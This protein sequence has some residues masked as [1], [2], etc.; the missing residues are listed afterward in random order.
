MEMN[1]TDIFMNSFG[2]IGNINV[3]THRE[4]IAVRSLNRM[5]IAC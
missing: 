3:S 5:H 1:A 4:I 2:F